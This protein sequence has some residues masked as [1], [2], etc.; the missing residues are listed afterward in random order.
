MTE[1]S[2]RADLDRRGLNEA[3]LARQLRLFADP[4]PPITLDRPCRLGDGIAQIDPGVAD[5]YVRAHEAA[6]CNG[7]CQKFVP[8][9]GAAT[10]MFQTLL[11]LRARFPSLTA[12]A[13]S[14]ATDTGDDDAR[15][16]L[17]FV[18]QL[19][20][21][22]FFPALARTLATR[23]L[24]ADALVDNGTYDE[25]V[26][27]LL[28]DS[29]LGYAALPKGL[30]DFHRSAGDIRTPFEEQLLEAAAYTS[31]ADGVC[32]LHVTVTADHLPAFVARFDAIRAKYESRLNAHFDVTFS[33]Q[34][35]ATDTV[36]VDR[37][38]APLRDADGRLVF[39]QSGH[40]A[41]LAN[42]ND[43][44]GDVIF[45]KNI[46]NVAPDLQGSSSLRWKRVLGGCLVRTQE[47]AHAHLRALH[48]AGAG[49]TEV[50]AALAFL[51]RCGVKL[52]T[53]TATAPLDHR[54]ALAIDRLDRP[55][56]VCGVV[57]NTGEPG[58]GPFW[59]TGENGTSTKQIVESAQV[60]DQSVD[61]V[62]IFGTATHF[63]PVDLV[64]GVR[65]WQGNPFD[66]HRYA[67]PSAVFISEKS[68]GT[69]RVQALEL[70][71]LWNGGMAHWLSLFVEVPPE[72]FTPVKTVTDLLRPDHQ[73]GPARQN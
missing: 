3:E 50:H 22:A 41:L 35:P 19:D 66:L 39:R 11:N 28:D 15:D 49:D 63:N 5:D 24:D 57:R 6:Q 8:A 13:L 44:Q 60:D 4:P 59:V 37:T 14:R 38:G 62:G 30:L 27:G 33:V 9:S 45:L 71:G 61:Q 10:R 43:L 70:P 7:R 64:C 1:P 73:P 65:D 40:G 25:L 29:G 18:T 16:V 31:D 52:P 69:Q 21:F 51:D 48:A 56:R 17:A 68:N 72:T 34:K 12:T 32:H 54:R 67:D 46:D 20:R 55:V 36:T 47:H 53:T 58:G 2:D 23:G 26:S 42:L